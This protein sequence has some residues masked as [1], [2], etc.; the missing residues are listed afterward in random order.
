LA[1]F[2]TSDEGG[3]KLNDP[4]TEDDLN[5]LTFNQQL[6]SEDG[7]IERSTLKKKK[8]TVDKSCYKTSLRTEKESWENPRSRRSAGRSGT[9]L[10]LEPS[11]EETVRTGKCPRC[12]S[13]K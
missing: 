2:E 6:E 5:L 13:G 3:Q 10:K 12:R 4:M 9:K 8:K 1:H 11:R 7:E